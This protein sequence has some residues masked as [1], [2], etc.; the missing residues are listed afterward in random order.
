MIQII[1]KIVC[2]WE[3]RKENWNDQ[4]NFLSLTS[5]SIHFN[6]DCETCNKLEDFISYWHT[7]HYINSDMVFCHIYFQNDKLI[8]KS[9]WSSAVIK[10]CRVVTGSFCLQE[11]GIF[12]NWLHN[13]IHN[14]YPASNSIKVIKRVGNNMGSVRST[15]GA[16][17]KYIHDPSRELYIYIYKL[18]ASV[19]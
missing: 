18:T 7:L 13:E 11:H 5:E 9:Y 10:V 1:H 14:L 12:Q 17:G 19:V 6:Q 16:D 15:D 8:E 2:E 3:G 4:L